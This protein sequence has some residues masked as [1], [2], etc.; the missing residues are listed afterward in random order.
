MFPSEMI[1]WFPIDLANYSSGP[2]DEC[3]DNFELAALPL[4]SVDS[5]SAVLERVTFETR[6][7]ALA[8]TVMSRRKD[9]KDEEDKDQN[10]T[11][12]L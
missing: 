12:V 5:V 4:V 2:T 11:L 9:K 8:D 10:E 3:Q 1:A 7:P 6:V